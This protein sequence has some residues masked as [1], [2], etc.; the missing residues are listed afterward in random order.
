MLTKFVIPIAGLKIGEHEFKWKVG[1]EFF[2]EFDYYEVNNG[3]I[4]VILTLVK[5]LNLMELYFH[6]K[7]YISCPC[8]RCAGDLSLLFN[9]NDMR[10][11]KFS[12]RNQID[13]EDFMVL[14]N[15]EHEIDVSHMVYETIV[16]G[17]PS[18]RAHGENLNSQ[19]CDS[20]ILSRLESFDE[21]KQNTIVDSRWSALNKLLTDKDK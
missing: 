2:K 1:G 12:S 14:G 6:A 11:V 18:R 20:D 21:R 17:L 13:T 15:D 8:D 19:K 7:G 3:D 4:N 16:L 10:V 9:H 5:K